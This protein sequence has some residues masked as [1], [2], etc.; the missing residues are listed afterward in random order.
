MSE[1]LSASHATTVTA[2]LRST[3]LRYAVM[4]GKSLLP[5][6]DFSDAVSDLMEALLDAAPLV[7]DPSVWGQGVTGVVEVVFAVE[8]DSRADLPSLVASI[9]NAHC[10]ALTVAGLTQRIAPHGADLPLDSPKDMLE[11]TQ[12]IVSGGS[13]RQR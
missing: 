9:T 6:T 7:I 8:V 13:K 4:G 11:L 10:D 5:N 1:Q 2:T 3:L 12:L